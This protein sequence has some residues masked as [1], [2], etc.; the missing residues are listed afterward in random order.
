MAGLVPAIQ[1]W[2]PTT[3]PRMRDCFR[4]IY[5]GDGQNMQGRI[6]NTPLPN[7]E[8]R[9]DVDGRTSPAMTV[10]GMAGFYT[11]RRVFTAAS[12]SKR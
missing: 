8:A 12:R 9:A 4:S 7:S 2:A 3:P 11:A 1:S 10:E 6:G 5:L